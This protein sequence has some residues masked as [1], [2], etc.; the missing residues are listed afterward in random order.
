MK[1][2]N[3][4]T[5]VGRLT[6]N[7]EC[8]EIENKNTEYKFRFMTEGNIKIAVDRKFKDSEGNIVT[9]FFNVYCYNKLAELAEEWL[10]KGDLVLITGKILTEDDRIKLLADDFTMLNK[11]K[12]ED[13]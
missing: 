7:P 13:A 1:S 4:F 2:Y 11:R 3:S 9:D 12:V 10:E 8:K 5:F 6:M